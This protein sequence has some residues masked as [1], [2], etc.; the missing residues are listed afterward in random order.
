MGGVVAGAHRRGKLTVG[1]R[2]GLAHISPTL[3]FNQRSNLSGKE[4][5]NL[6]RKMPV[7]VARTTTSGP[8]IFA[9]RGVWLQAEKPLMKVK[10]SITKTLT[11]RPVLTHRRCT[12]ACG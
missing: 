10:K 12:Q 9:P 6:T 2:V 1:V 7:A 5:M 4:R 11:G 8:T 3:R